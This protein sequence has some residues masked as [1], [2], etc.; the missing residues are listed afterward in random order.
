MA[1]KIKP[2]VLTFD[3]AGD[4]ERMKEEYE[5]IGREVNID[6]QA[7][8]LTVL[9]LPRKYKKKSIK[10]TKNARKKEKEESFGDY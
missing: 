5:F 4:L 6:R 8:K 3:N 7:M 9:T 10:E 2:L 1:K